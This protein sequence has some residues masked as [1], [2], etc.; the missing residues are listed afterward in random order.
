MRNRNFV[1]CLAAAAILFPARG[2][3]DSAPATG[4]H[5]RYLE[6]S[7]AAQQDWTK[8]GTREIAGE[9]TQVFF[10]QADH[11]C[12]Q[13][14]R[15]ES[16]KHLRFDL[17]ATIE[18]NGKI[19]ETAIDPVTMETACFRDVMRRQRLKAR[20]AAPVHIRIRMRPEGD[21][22]AA[23]QRIFNPA[24]TAS[25]LRLADS[26]R[27][28]A[29]LQPPRLEHR[30]DVRLSRELELSNAPQ[31]SE[32]LFRIDAHGRVALQ[33][34]ISSSSD[35]WTAA[36]RKALEQW[37]FQPALCDGEPVDV[38]FKLS[39]QSAAG[40]IRLSGKWDKD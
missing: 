1:V 9:L 23:D 5:A 14:P 6:L 27:H 3:D 29:A 16:V 36:V 8:P 10:A 34:V 18:T 25:T 11:R 26:G 21:V 22:S 2:A 15:S 19:S 12:V 24:G 38:L 40:T 35:D 13:P 20:P 37:T 39:S 31:Q 28:C 7:A 17:I 33:A 30:V 4:E 32:L